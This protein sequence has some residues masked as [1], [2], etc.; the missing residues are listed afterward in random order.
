[1]Q[2]TGRR[3]SRRCQG[4]GAGRCLCLGVQLEKGVGFRALAMVGGRL[5]ASLGSGITHSLPHPRPTIQPGLS[6]CLPVDGE[7][8]MGC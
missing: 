7:R 8:K 1:M 3:D 5:S 4:Q 6:D 2:E